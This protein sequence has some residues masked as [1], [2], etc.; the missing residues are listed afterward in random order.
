M[1]LFAHTCLVYFFMERKKK[2]INMFT[3]A[4]SQNLSFL[5]LTCV[6]YH[7]GHA[8]FLFCTYSVFFTRSI[9]NFTGNYYCTI[10]M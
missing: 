7:N 8:E 6:L 5:I 9:V 2:K 4:T 3:Q 1:P 10:L